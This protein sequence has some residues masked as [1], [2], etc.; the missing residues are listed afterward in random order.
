VCHL[1]FDALV[2]SS[3]VSLCQVLMLGGNR[4]VKCCFRLTNRGNVRSASTLFSVFMLRVLSFRINGLKLLALLLLLQFDVS[5]L[6][7]QDTA[8]KDQ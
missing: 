5:F 2:Q 3:N 8:V 6:L 1:P 7:C 4:K